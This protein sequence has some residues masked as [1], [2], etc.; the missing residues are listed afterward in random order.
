MK[1]YSVAALKDKKLAEGISIRSIWGEKAMLTFFELQPGAIIPRHAHP[2]EQI[3]YVLE[4][5]L[6]FTVAGNKKILRPGEGV[7]VAPNEEHEAKVT[8]KFTRAMDA[9]APIR[10]DYKIQ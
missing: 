3:T 7:V 5:E 9:W 2:N 10:E 8:G 1:F 4:G 6:E